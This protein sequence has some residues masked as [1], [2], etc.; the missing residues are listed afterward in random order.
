MADQTYTH[1]KEEIYYNELYDKFTIEE[2]RRWEDKKGLWDV[3]SVQDKD[4]MQM[5]IKINFADNVVLP[6][7]LYV[8]KGERYAKKSETI[9]QWMAQDRAKDELVANTTEPRGIRCLTCS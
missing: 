8:I 5:K 4:P 6:V 2:C 3:P 9:R 7:A 1:L